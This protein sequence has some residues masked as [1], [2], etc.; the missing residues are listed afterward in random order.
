MPPGPSMSAPQVRLSGSRASRICASSASRPKK[1]W[2]R[3]GL[4]GMEVCA[5]RASG[6]EGLV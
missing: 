4:L 6:D 1:G 2:R 5:G 3:G